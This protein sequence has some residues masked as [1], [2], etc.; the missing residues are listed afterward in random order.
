MTSITQLIASG[1]PDVP[2]VLSVA[3]RQKQAAILQEERLRLEEAARKRRE[4]QRAELDQQR[5][6]EAL[7][8][9]DWEK[10][11]QHLL[12]NAPSM[13]PAFNK[14]RIEEE[15]AARE[16]K[17]DENKAAVEYGAQV[18]KAIAG[19]I[20]L[21][22]EEESAAA[23]PAAVASFPEL[24]NVEYPGRENLRPILGVT[25]L[26][27]DLHAREL[28]LKQEE[29]LK[30]ETETAKLKAQ[31]EADK[32]QAGPKLPEAQRIWVD[33]YRR[34]NPGTSLMDALQAYDKR[35]AVLRPGVDVPFPPDVTKQKKELA[36]AGR[37]DQGKSTLM[38]VP[39]P[40]GGQR[41]VEVRPGTVLPPGARMPGQMG[42][43]VRAS[44]G[45]E[46]QSLAYY[47]RMKDA[48]DTIM[49]PGPGGSIED[50]VGKGGLARQV[51]LKLP[52]LLQKADAQVYT[53]AQRAFTE[54]RLRKE[55]GAAIPP[56]EYQND[57][58]TYFA[59]PGDTGEVITR[60]RVGRQKLLDGLAFT[61]GKAYE[62]FYGEQRPTPNETT[63]T[64]ST[65]APQAG[66]IVTIKGKRQQITKVYPDGSFDAEPIKEK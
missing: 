9:G 66:D 40:E 37:A 17:E 57:A 33:E 16:A 26:G 52:S 46:R 6:S 31:I 12:R 2:E 10:G 3:E 50:I 63:T 27:R 35:T 29:R 62:E 59:Q 41:V 47:N 24:A 19:V 11:R 43:L 1:G 65:A 21:P 28:Q 56:H 58:K 22:S 51:E 25:A 44:T 13:Y 61:S 49:A 15:K 39:T 7:A 23:W 60:K 36:E 30:I 48:I 8:L 18:A 45:S 20:G 42:N 53:Q 64:T 55:S 5:M 54:A 14:L 34:A 4:A 32:A 38:V